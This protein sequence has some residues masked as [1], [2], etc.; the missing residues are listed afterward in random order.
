MYRDDREAKIAQLETQIQD[1]ETEIA[2]LKADLKEKEPDTSGNNM[3]TFELMG[4][5]IKELQPKSST[6]TDPLPRSMWLAMVLV[7]VAIVAG[8]ALLLLTS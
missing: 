4:E 6:Y 5:L 8:F 1:R 2:Q 3:A 7:S